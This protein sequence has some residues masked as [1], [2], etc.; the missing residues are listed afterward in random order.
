MHIFVKTWTGRTIRLNV[1]SS[2]TIKCVKHMIWGKD[3]LPP[4]EQVLTYC[5]QLEETRT[6]HFYNIQNDV[7]L[8]LTLRLRG[9]M[10][11]AG[12]KVRM[13]SQPPTF[14][15]FIPMNKCVTYSRVCRVCS[16]TQLATGHLCCPLITVLLKKEWAAANLRLCFGV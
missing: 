14:P 9:G 10:E 7:T 6:L 1:K 15:P 11:D 12:H 5:C 16:S 3:L 2:D 8:H 4:C 13:A